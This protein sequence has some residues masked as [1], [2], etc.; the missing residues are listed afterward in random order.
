MECNVGCRRTDFF[1]PEQKA[2]IPLL[3]LYP[4]DVPP[5]DEQFGPYELYVAS[6]AR[7]KG[8]NRT[9]I[10]ISHGNGG[11]PW[12]Y[13]DLAVF[14]ATSGFVVALPEHIGNSRTDNNL[15]GT[16]ANLQNR[17]RHITL[18]IDATFADPS[19]GNI[20]R[21][22]GVGLIGHSIGGYTALSVAGGQPWTTPRESEG[23]EPYPLKVPSD[24]RVRALVLLA[25]ATPW[26]IPTG[27]LANVRIPVLLR[28]GEKDQI[29]LGWHADIVKNGVESPGLIDHRNIAGAGHFS[30]MSKFPPSMT[31]PDFAPSQ[32]PDGFDRV[33]IQ[34]SLHSDIRNF[35]QRV[36]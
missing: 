25:P 11:T 31:R 4:T 16:A 21:P 1:D 17:P 5:R 29:T 27:S 33:D 12:A 26:F 24:P 6:D 23:R 2:T 14:L 28:T 22:E 19:V 7:A 35:L 3:L 18:A 30:F 15:D 10:V 13:R 9:L 8:S 36:L 34:H 20:L 32:D